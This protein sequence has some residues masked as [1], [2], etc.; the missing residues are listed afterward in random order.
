MHQGTGFKAGLNWGIKFFGQIR[1]RVGKIADF[2]L[3]FAWP[4]LSR[5]ELLT[6]TQFLWEYP[7]RGFHST[8]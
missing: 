3:K 6:P 8:G 5:S 7:L 4:R 2:G 1:N